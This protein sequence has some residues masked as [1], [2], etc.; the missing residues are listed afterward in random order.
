MGEIP[1][2]PSR[3]H[4]DLFNTY[5]SYRFPDHYPLKP[6]TNSDE[7][8]TLFEAVRVHGSTGQTF[9]ST[10]RPGFSRGDHY[11]LSKIERFCVLRGQARISLRK[12][13]DDKVIH[14]DVSGDEPAIVDMP[15]MWVHNITNVGDGRSLDHVLGRPA[16][17]PCRSGYLLGICRDR[18]GHFA[19]TK[20][21]TIVGTRPEIIRLSRVIVRLDDTVDHVF[22]HTGQNYDH[23]L[24]QV[25]FD[26]LGL[27]APDTFLEVDTS[28]LG[29]V[30]GETLI[31]TETGSE[32][33]ATGR[34]AGLWV[35]QT[36]ASLPSWPSE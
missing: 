18:Q 23:A 29:R 6:K 13:L 17:E 2:L 3:F 26:D 36:A 34:R 8:G 4:V 12:I 24:N 21:M 32:A 5:R 27:R 15:T 11:H 7:R 19:M 10:T 33:G 20:V 14:F 30:L 1:A 31:K 28:S 22:V 25:F 16:P 9:L 35:T